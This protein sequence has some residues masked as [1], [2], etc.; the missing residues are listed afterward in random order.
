MSALTQQKIDNAVA[1]MGAL[2]KFVNDSSAS[3]PLTTRLGRSAKNLAKLGEDVIALTSDL[4]APGIRRAFE[5]ST[6]MGAPAAGGMRFNNATITSATAFSFSNTSVD[7]GNPDDSNFVAQFGASSNPVPAVLVFR[8]IGAP[9]VFSIFNMVSVVTDNTSWLTGALSYIAGAGSLSVADHISIQ[10]YRT[11]DKGNTGNT[12]SAGSA[13]GLAMVN[14]TIAESHSAGAVTFALK[15]ATG[16]DPSGGS[17]VTVFFLTGSGAYSA[18]DVTSALS[19]TVSSGSTL[20]IGSGQP[21]QLLLVAINNAGAVELGILSRARNSLFGAFIDES[22]L[23]SSTAEG[24]AGAADSGATIYSAS[25]R[26]NKTIR[27]IA[28]ADYTAGITVAG[29]WDASPVRTSLQIPGESKGLPAS[30]YAYKSTPQTGVLHEVYTKVTWDSKRWDVGGFFDTTNS[31][32]TPPAGLV[33]QEV[34]LWLTAHVASS[35]SA[36]VLVKVYKNAVLQDVAAGAGMP[37][38]GFPGTGSAWVTFFDIA[39]GTDYYEVEVYCSSDNAGNNIQIDNNP[40][41]VH[42]SGSVIGGAC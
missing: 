3:S 39:S 17:P 11:G 32:W 19:V 7:S 30:F 5:T 37:N 16:A 2:E 9:E 29:T 42:W 8:K 41:H 26:S 14:G 15:T 24:G 25:A 31:R 10:W 12:G 6:T 22:L 13:P 36:T 27:V 40:A 23:Y 33:C 21:F 4:I 28:R 18:I 1:D 35:A 34:F 20:G 38:C